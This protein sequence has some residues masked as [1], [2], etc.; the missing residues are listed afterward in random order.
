MSRNYEVQVEVFPCTQQQSIT[1]A[2]VLGKW[3]MTVEGETECFDDNYDD[4]WSYW[5]SSQLC[6]GQTEQER[7][8]SLRALLPEHSI[9]T[10]WRWVD[11]LSWDEELFSEPLTTPA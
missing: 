7:H 6:G 2:T 8:E 10:R 5:G 11:E 3:G 1:I 9:N 4:G